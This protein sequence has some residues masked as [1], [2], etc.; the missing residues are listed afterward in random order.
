MLTIKLLCSNLSRLDRLDRIR[1]G[2]LLL[3]M[4]TDA[5]AEAIDR[6]SISVRMAL[7]RGDREVILE[8]LESM[9]SER[10]A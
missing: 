7:S 10:L 5:A 1:L 6:S 2:L 9:I 3:G 4:D 8:R